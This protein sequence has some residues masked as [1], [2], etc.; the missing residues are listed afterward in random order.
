MPEERKPLAVL[1]IGFRK[2]GEERVLLRAPVVKNGRIRRVRAPRKADVIRIGVLYDGENF[3]E[4]YLPAKIAAKFQAASDKQA[5]ADRLL[6]PVG[7]LGNF[8]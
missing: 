1:E 4:I 5:K 6:G 3:R 8:V 7:K 2:V